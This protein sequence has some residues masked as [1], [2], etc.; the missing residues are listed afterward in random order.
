[1]INPQAKFLG[2]SRLQRSLLHFACSALT[3]NIL[4]GIFLI[5]QQLRSLICTEKSANTISVIHSVN[6]C[7]SSP[8]CSNHQSESSNTDS[9]DAPFPDLPLICKELIHRPRTDRGGEAHC[10]SPSKQTL[11]ERRQAHKLRKGIRICT[12]VTVRVKPMRV[13]STSSLRRHGSCN[14]YKE[15]WRFFQK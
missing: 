3:I 8:L 10:S 2:Y 1:M 13:I 12:L 11:A 7:S 9:A 6:F 14:L 15:A 4:T 5:F